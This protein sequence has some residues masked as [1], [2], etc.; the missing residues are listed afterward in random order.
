VIDVVSGLEVKKFLPLRTMFPFQEVTRSQPTTSACG[1]H[2][3]SLVSISKRSTVMKFLAPLVSDDRL[4][5]THSTECDYERAMETSSS[6]ANI[7]KRLYPDINHYAGKRIRLQQQYLW[8]A[9]SLSDIMR[10]FKNIGK[11]I[12]EFPSCMCSPLSYFGIVRS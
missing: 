12:S 10:R 1:A 2:S 5:Q 3:P 8:C 4:T 9:A 11:P 7:T 6:V